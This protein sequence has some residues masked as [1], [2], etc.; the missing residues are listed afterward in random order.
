MATK[1]QDSSDRAARHARIA[2]D[3]SWRSRVAK[4]TVTDPK[5]RQEAFDRATSLIKS[6]A[7]INTISLDRD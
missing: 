5:R 4:P 1:P 7:Q 2:I 3:D 6:D